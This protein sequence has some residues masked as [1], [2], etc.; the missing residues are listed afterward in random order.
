MRL[1]LWDVS[2]ENIQNNS[3]QQET[4]KF[5]FHD[6]KNLENKNV[7]CSLTESFSAT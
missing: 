6:D 7:V 2:H 1:S 4:F 5:S 3:T